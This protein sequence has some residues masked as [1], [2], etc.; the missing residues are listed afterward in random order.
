MDEPCSA[1]DPI[2][3]LEIEDLMHELKSDYT[4]VIV[5]HN[6]Q[7]AARVS[8]RT[9]SSSSTLDETAATA[10]FTSV[11]TG[12]EIFMSPLGERPA[13]SS[14]GT[15]STPWERHFHH[16]PG[17][18]SQD[19]LSGWRGCA[20]TALPQGDGGAPDAPDLRIW[21]TRSWPRTWRARPDRAPTDRGPSAPTSSACS[22]RWR[23]RPAIPRRRDPRLELP[24][25]I[26]DHSGEHRAERGQALQRSLEPSAHDARRR[27][28]VRW[29]I[30]ARRWSAS[31]STRSRPRDIE[32]ARV[33]GRAR[34]ADRPREPAGRR[35]RP[36][37]A[38]LDP[39]RTEW[40]MRMI[41]VSRCLERIGD[42]AVD[43]GEQT[44]FLVTGEFH[45]F[46]RRLA[47]TRT[48]RTRRPSA[49]PDAEP[50]LCGHGRSP[51]PASPAAA[52]L[53]RSNRRAE[54]RRGRD[55]DREHEDD[56]VTA[57]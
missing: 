36:R 48:S 8:D 17:E 40:G 51:G 39:R 10:L 27:P 32:R 50:R 2:A 34:R 44:A 38:R 24:R 19:R 22:S 31:R 37:D 5:T 9:A 14:P 57:R 12:R 33:A 28:R 11:G 15:G 35:Q 29:A 26:G 4:I 46:T 52:S 25:A 3:T 20:E 16:D 49:R 30:A 42:N 6:L 13:A 18:P 41:V 1:L 7:Q 45:E 53:R 21:P 47:L 54:E 56:H 55:Q 23:A 43:I